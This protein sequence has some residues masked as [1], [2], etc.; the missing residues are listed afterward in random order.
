MIRDLDMQAF[1]EYLRRLGLDIESDPQP[2]EEDDLRNRGVAAPLGGALHPTVYGALA[3]G[4]IPQSY[5]QT[6][7]FRVEC[8]AYHGPDRASDVLQ[9]ADASGRLDEQV[10]R[11]VGWFAGLGRFESYDDGLIRED[12]YLLAAGGAEGVAGQRGGASGL[13]HHRIQDAP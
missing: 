8:V 11:A 10:D 2:R 13:R 3:F 12:R 9:V 7:D 6:R 5:P 4:K 1:G